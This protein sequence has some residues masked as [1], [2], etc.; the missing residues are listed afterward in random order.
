MSEI[1]QVFVPVHFFE[2]NDLQTKKISLRLAKTCQ[3]CK[4]SHVVD[5]NKAI[6]PADRLKK[7]HCFTFETYSF[8]FLQIH[9]I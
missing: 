5:F 1:C 6:K 2:L 8:N 7:P 4:Q 3:L 9:M